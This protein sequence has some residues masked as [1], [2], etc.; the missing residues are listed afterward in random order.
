MFNIVKGHTENQE[1][2]HDTLKREIFEETGITSFNILT[3]L[4]NIKYKIMKAGF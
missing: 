3:Y 4:G 1:T 2:D